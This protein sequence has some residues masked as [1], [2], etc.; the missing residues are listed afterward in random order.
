MF[1]DNNKEIYNFNKYNLISHE[2]SVCNFIIM[3][4]EKGTRTLVKI[5]LVLSHGLA[6]YLPPC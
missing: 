1:Y 6:K 5:K 4:K 3:K 2:K